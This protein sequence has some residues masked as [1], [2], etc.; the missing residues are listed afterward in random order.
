MAERVAGEMGSGQVFGQYGSRD[1]GAVD[2]GAW[3][4]GFAG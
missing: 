4:R 2:E 3:Q 1:G